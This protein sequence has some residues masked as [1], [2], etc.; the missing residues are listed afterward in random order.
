MRDFDFLVPTRVVFGRGRL[1]ELG[2]HVREHG[3]R[4]LLVC[5]RGAMRRHGVLD[6]V[7][8]L[9]RVAGVEVTVFE[10][11]SPDPTATEADRAAALAAAHGCEVVVGLGGGSAIDAAKAAAVGVAWGPV[12]PLV[13]T[14]LA[15]C[16]GVLPVIAVPT[17]AGTGSEITRGA[18]L[19][20]PQRALKAG[21]RGPDLFPRVALVDPAL[22]ATVPPRVAAQSGFDALAHAVEGLVARRADPLSSALA[23]RAVTL[24]AEH[25][26]CTAAGKV[27]AR[28]QDAMALAALFGG[29]NVACAGT[30]LPH[31][32][33]QAMARVPHTGVSHGRGLALLYPA[34]LQVAHPHAPERFDTVAALLGG[35]DIHTAIADLLRTCGLDGK[36]RDQGFTPP[37][38]ATMAEGVT[39]D[40]GNDPIDC[41]RP[42]TVEEIYRASY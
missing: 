34:W 30:C 23:E 32:M 38:L 28:V 36:L 13:G 31:R 9:L 10:G 17:T 1:A 20:D 12:G 21:I 37:D 27:T 4:A 35:P 3:R 22:L 39:G 41:V 24:L 14:T 15:P 11:V 29:V 40:L 6:T 42:E 8:G 33:Q 18:T 7:V 16:E 19:T 26:P 5:G 25:L 2:T